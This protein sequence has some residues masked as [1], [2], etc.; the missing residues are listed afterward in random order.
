[1]KLFS[2]QTLLINLDDG[3]LTVQLNRPKARNALNDQMIDELLTVCAQLQGNSSIRALVLRGSEG[4]FCAGADLKSLGIDS[5]NASAVYDNNRLFGTLIT[6]FNKLDQV[7]ITALEGSVLGGGLGLA[8][9]SDFSVCTTSAR[10]A[11][12]ETSLGIPPAQIAP[13]VLHRIGIT[14]TRRL[15]LLGQKV[16]GQ[17]AAELGL[18]HQCVNSTEELSAVIDQAIA[19]VKRCAPQANAMTK[20]LLL[21]MAGQ[22]SGETLNH[23]ADLF[24]QS[25]YGPEGR[26]GIKAFAEKRAPEWAQQKEG[27]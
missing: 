19:D 21:S 25:V 18:V 4:H 2:F 5:N 16:T 20:Q 10:F 22:P 12:P 23:A 27:T 1:M 11:M 3:I 7:V 9:I 8:C 6:T 13:F 15:A 14:Q 26:E 17:Q 24:S